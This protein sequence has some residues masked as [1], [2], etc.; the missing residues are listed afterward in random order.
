M[1]RAQDVGSAIA[2]CV[3]SP[4]GKYYNTLIFHSCLQIWFT[5]TS[6]NFPSGKMSNNTRTGSLLEVRTIG[7]IC[8]LF[9][10]KIE[11]KLMANKWIQICALPIRW[12]SKWF[13]GLL[14]WFVF[15]TGIVRIHGATTGWTM[16]ALTGPK[17]IQH[18]PEAWRFNRYVGSPCGNRHDVIVRQC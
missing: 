10:E 3:A 8:I 4:W 5:I 2:D 15:V 18:G 14:S 9:V 17:Q 1:G 7:P 11:R 6:F 13:L 16:W 12:H